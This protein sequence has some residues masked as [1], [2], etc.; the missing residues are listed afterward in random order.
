MTEPQLV[1]TAWT[2]AG[3]ASPRR[4]PSTSP[5]PIAERVAAVA[6]ARYVGMGLIAADLLAIRDSIGFA[7]LR[8]MI[9]DHGLAHVEIE[10]IQRWWIPRGERGHTY[11][12]R[13]LL[14]EAAEV[15]SP[16]F[17]KIGSELGPRTTHPESLIAPLRELAEEAAD[18]GTKI[19]IETM[20]FSIIATVPMG[21]DIVAAADH[22]AVGLLVDAWHVFRAGTSLEELRESLTPEMI[23]GV[24]LDDAAD[25]VVG[26]LFEDTVDR[27]LLCDEGCFDLRGLVEVLRDKGFDGPWGVEI[28]STSFRKLPV[29]EALP[30]AAESARKVL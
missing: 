30:L 28:L 9:A 17:I 25:K 6:D 2:S 23:F 16:T 15:L 5:V 8:D 1:A 14:F 13:D 20:P 27:R 18:R 3:D 26:T 21:A 12:V 22:P 7:G 24:E 19:A 4:I 10:L 11:D 29:R